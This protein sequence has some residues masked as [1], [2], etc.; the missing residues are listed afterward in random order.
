MGSFLKKSGRPGGIR[1]P[2]T[3]I[4]RPLLYRWSYWPKETASADLPFLVCRVLP[5]PRAE[6]AQLELVLLLSA[7]LGRGVVALLADGA[8]QRDQASITFRHKGNALSQRASPYVKAC[9]ALSDDLGH[10]ARADGA[11]AL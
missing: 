10:N 8:L 9:K 1:T 6:L 11:A 5:A 7:V 4:W 2:N 3:R